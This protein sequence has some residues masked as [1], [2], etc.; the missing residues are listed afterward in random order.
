MYNFNLNSGWGSVLMHQIGASVGPII[1]RIFFVIED[2]D[3]AVIRDMMRDLVVPDPNGT[4]RFFETLEEAYDACT[5]NANDVIVLNGQ[6]T[7]AVATGIAWS[8]SRIH[9]IG[10]DGGDRLVQQGAKIELSGA[11]DSAYVLKV[12]GTRN[13]FENLKILQSSSHANALNVVQ[14]AGEGTKWKNCSFM[15]GTTDNTDLTTSAEALMGEDSGTFINCSF[16]NDNLLST[17]ARNVMAFDAIT[18]ASSADGAK[19]NRFVDCEWII[20]SSSASAQL[21]KVIDTAGAKF[22]NSFIRPRFHA[23]VSTGGGGIAL[24]NAVQSVASFVDGTFDFYAP[25]SFNC[26]NFCST[27]NAKFQVWAP[28]SSATGAEAI[29]PT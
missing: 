23:I 1:G 13:T 22:L 25:A 17:G 4:I 7:H 2:S 10:M 20:Q 29:Q 19:N 12:T 6:T 16:G 26:T 9:V 3:P 11:V 8:K 27:L 24:T 28:A 21:I 5:T 15:F 14:F 18:G